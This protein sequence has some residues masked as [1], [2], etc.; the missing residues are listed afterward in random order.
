MAFALKLWPLWVLLACNRGEAPTRPTLLAPVTA[1]FPHQ[2][3]Q[4]DL[5]R[6]S[7]ID[8][9]ETGLAEGAI[10]FTLDNRYPTEG[11]KLVVAD[12]WTTA[13]VWL[14]EIYLGQ[15]TGGSFPG[16]IEV[17]DFLRPGT[18]TLGLRVR[19]PGKK[20]GLRQGARKEVG[21]AQASVGSVQL[22]LAP[23]THIEWLALP[24]KSGQI[25]AKA[26][27]PNAPEGARVRF[28]AAL[29]GLL[30]QALGEAVVQNGMAQAEAV[31][32]TGPTWSPQTGASAL[33]QFTA[34]LLSQSGEALDNL[35]LRSGLRETKATS[36]GFLL[37]GKPTP[38]VAVRMEENW[39]KDGT[40]LDELLQAGINSIEIHGTYPPKFWMELCDEAGIQVVI[41]PRCDGEVMA[42]GRDVLAIKK[43]L[44]DQQNR[45]SQSMLGHPSLLFWTTE[46]T[47]ELMDSLADTFSQDPLERPVTGGDIPAISISTRQLRPLRELKAGAWITEIT[48]PPGTGPETA[49][50]LF[51]A[52]LKKGAIGG[53]LPVDRNHPAMRKIWLNLLKTL[54]DSLE[55]SLDALAPKRSNSVVQVSGAKAKTTIWLE[56]PFSMPKGAITDP[57]GAATLSTFHEGE[58][59][60]AQGPEIRP[61]H[62]LANTRQG[63]QI[64]SVE[65]RIQWNRP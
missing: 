35:S 15:L 32:W 2:Q 45:L 23:A 58:A 61:V 29:D 13:E 36:E 1:Q 30:F 21:Y 12:L 6:M 25:R 18:H 24:L 31:D 65:K 42:K 4:L 27:V 41:L 54:T 55:I 56:A 28:E 50:H 44:T 47:P 11:A 7:L 40:N 59:Q 9:S 26:S 51:Q 43:E 14:D 8:G 5:G 17:G 49:I 20:S 52:A 57:R 3:A 34:T 10:Q 60:L 46:G 19:S 33:F 16:E 63:N 39:K 64:K 53:V 48:N 38:I 37:N 62:L 22:H